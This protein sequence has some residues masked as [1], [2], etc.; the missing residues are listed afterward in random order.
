MA[1]ITETELPSIET[2]MNFAG[3]IE[4]R[5][6][7]DV[8][9]WSR[10]NLVL[11][12][13]DVRIADARP[14]RDQFSLDRQGFVLLD[15]EAGLDQDSDLSIEAPEYL[16]SVGA[17]L[18][19]VSGADLV[20]PQGKGLLKRY[21]ERAGVEGAIG[22]SRWAH[23]DYTHYAA[24]KW[25]EWMEGWEGREL[26]QYPRFVIFQTWRCLSPPPQ[27]NTLVLCDS[28]SIR[29]EDCI[30]FDAC[31]AKPYDAPGNQFESQ[32]CPYDPGQRW[33]FFSNLMPNELIVWKAFDSDPA[34]DAQPL[35]NSAD[36][37]GLPDG[38]APRVS[39]EARFFAFFE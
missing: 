37:P 33:Y 7:V 13:H 8:P 17:L 30:T 26:R 19:Q 18:K 32:L 29:A 6:R 39:V 12:K 3:H 28:S 36:I 4:G 38:S 2:W 9:D 22:P 23:M 34:R 1:T 16:A 15:H 21:A 31:L 5:A 10:T 27:D 25:V 20:L 11:E 14:I 35:H 24:H